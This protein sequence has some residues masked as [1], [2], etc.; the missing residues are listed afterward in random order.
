MRFTIK[1]EYEKGEFTI[2][3]DSIADAHNQTT[4]L[5]KISS[6][7]GKN[8]NIPDIGVIHKTSYSVAILIIEI[9]KNQRPVKCVEQLLSEEVYKHLKYRTRM[10]TKIE[11]VK[12]IPS[13]KTIYIQASALKDYA[14]VTLT[15]RDGNRNRAFALKIEKS[16]ERWKITEL[17]YA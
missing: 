5:K 2:H 8:L 10:D 17:E 12:T 14:D 11:N 4:L 3:A 6:S 7:Y 13:L 1:L 16:K 9:L 15:V